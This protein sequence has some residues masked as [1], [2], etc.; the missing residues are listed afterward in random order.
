MTY[1][2]ILFT[3]HG[4]TR[5]I[6]AYRI[7]MILR[8]Q[9]YKVKVVDF[10]EILIQ[11]A[12]YAKFILKLHEEWVHENTI[13]GF[14]ATFMFNFL[15]HAKRKG[16]HGLTL[17]KN[18]FRLNATR[19]ESRMMKSKLRNFQDYGDD[20]LS[21]NDKL[22]TFVDAL[23]D[24]FPDNK[25][26]IGGKGEMVRHMY[27]MVDAD[28]LFVGYSEETATNQLINIYN[29]KPTEKEI[30]SGDSL[31]WD[32]HNCGTTFHSS[33]LI[34]PNEALPLEIS[35]GCRFKCKFCG[36]SLLGRK[37]SDK[38][39]RNKEKIW[40]ELIFNYENF[41]TTNYNIL[42]D[43]FN[44][45]TE[46]LLVIKDL[47]DRFKNITGKQIRFACYLRLE[48]IHRYPEQIQIMKD[49]GIMACQFGIESLNYESAKAV[50]KGIRTEDVYSTIQAVRDSWG[51][52]V[53]LWSGFIIGLPH[54]NK[55]TV[56]QW[57]GDLYNKKLSLTG[58]KLES[59]RIG[60]GT[61]KVF[62]S[63]FE[64]NAEKYGYTFSAKPMEDGEVVWE[65][66]N[67]HWNFSECD[68]I[69]VE[70]GQ[71]FVND[72]IVD[73]LDRPWDYLNFKN[74]FIPYKNPEIYSQYFDKV[75][76]EEEG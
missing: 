69:A 66:E 74:N 7:A 24:F 70:W 57:L 45:T 9:G 56:N 51:P 3:P 46:K 2:F 33:D 1:D 59:L 18:V 13:F 44:E 64:R 17:K 73:Y 30:D 38:Y 58:W 76:A 72:G 29:N 10:L 32:F 65:W 11:E 22:F 68:N 49:M 19:S 50:G 71:K 4:G 28:H 27:E 26:V 52:D 48:L 8:E 23:K 53:C 61:K 60:Y 16:P 6:G 43:T 12:W 35:R 47:F 36:F 20:T 14:S 67:E 21:L 55:E 25:I 54:D 15:G 75:M 39:I 63:E 41:G 34:F 37:V 40:E 31:E 62:V 5:K 42:C